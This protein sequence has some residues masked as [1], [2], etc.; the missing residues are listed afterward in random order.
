MLAI[1]VAAHVALSALGFNPTDDGFILA[2]SRRILAGE[3]P[4]RDF[5][6][7]RPAGSAVL[8]VVDLWIGGAHTFIVS[9]L[10]YWLEVAVGCWAW[11]EIAIARLGAPGLVP[12]SLPLGALAFMLSTHAFQPMAWHTVDGVALASVGFLLAGT[13]ARGAAGYA[14]IGAAAVCKQNFLPLIPA[15]ILLRGDHGRPVAWAAALIMP[16]L[17]VAALVVGGG[18]SD[19]FH[20]LTAKSDL[21]QSGIRQYVGRPWAGIGLALGALPA[22]VVHTGRGRPTRVWLSLLFTGAIAAGLGQSVDHERFQYIDRDAFLLFGASSGVLLGSMRRPFPASF[23][24]AA[25]F[26]LALGW[27]SSVSEGYQTPA[28]A[29]G[30]LVIVLVGGIM[31]LVDESARRAARRAA[32]AVSLAALAWVAPHWRS[33]RR[34]HI[35]QELTAPLLT[36]DLAGVF[37]GAAGIR[38]NAN[39][40]AALAELRQ[41]VDGLGS[42]PYAILVDAPGW[43]A[44]ARQR[45]PLPA[46][47]PQSMEI[48]TGELEDR[49]SR[50]ILAL[51]ERGIVIVQNARMN[52]I[53]ERVDP[54]PRENGYYGAASWARFALRRESAHR[55][56]DVYR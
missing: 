52:G 54:I 26:A 43:W 47:W 42:T 48:C 13:G 29:A 15:T 28:H 7:V 21:V 18:G 8:H 12:W 2:Q 56:W 31:A 46:D 17:Y 50:R 32:F 30:P 33:A 23:A 16:A 53:A 9:R 49:V 4:H 3:V 35:A 11:L 37:P 38:T 41:I 1:A 51:R 36:H 40:F 10:I 34:D 14:L 24:A 5:I 55:Y 22:L 20:Q 6:T 44:C 25:A 45:N 39:T 27:C 19:L